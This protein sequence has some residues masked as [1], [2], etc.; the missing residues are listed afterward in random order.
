MKMKE[1][2]VMSIGKK[3]LALRKSLGLSQEQ[4]AQDLHVSRQ[5]ISKYEADLSLPNM[6]TIL[7][8]C[9]L[10]HVSITEL[11]GIDESKTDLTTQLFD[12][13]SLVTSNLE[14][15]KN[16]RKVF[17][18]VLVGICVVSLFFNV[19]N[20]MRKPQQVIIDKGVTNVTTTQEEKVFET[21]SIDVLGYHL[22]EMMMD[23]KI[24]CSVKNRNDNSLVTCYMVDRSG[25]QYE[26]TLENSKINEYSYT[27]QIPLMDYEKIIFE[28][29]TQGEMKS[30][31]EAECD[32]LRNILEQYVCIGIPCE[33]KETGY[34][35]IHYDQIKYYEHP[36]L[37]VMLGDI[38]V[39]GKMQGKMHL[40][41]RKLNS[42]GADTILIDR[43]IDLNCTG[44]IQLDK[45]IDRYCDI[46]ITMEVEVDGYTCEEIYVNRKIFPTSS[47][48]TTSVGSVISVYEY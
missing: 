29:N 19:Y 27:G 45:K 38:P 4:M 44:D 39:D 28:M 48:Q 12:Q 1:G 7:L 14:K 31:R 21:K 2:V 10:Y 34:N 20:F 15:E 24:S 41:I 46:T 8:M 13:M 43:D 5:T 33:R 17:D 37:S 25:K 3:I 32:Y 30:E 6:E 35:S 18:F 22:D 16:R 40:V 47:T 26:Y 11:L 42:K 23:V 9:E 36:S